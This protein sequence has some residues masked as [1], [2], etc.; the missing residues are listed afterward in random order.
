M[1]RRKFI[2]DA[3][4][5][6]A[7]AI[8]LAPLTASAQ[9]PSIQWKMQTS[10]ARGTDDSFKLLENFGARIATI[11]GDKFKVQVLPENEAVPNADLIGALGKGS[12]DAALTSGGDHIHVDKSFAF[13]SGMPFGMNARIQYAW[14]RF[15]G[16]REVLEELFNAHKLVHLPGGNTGVQ[17]AGFF[18]KEIKGL[19]DLNGLK[20]RVGGIGGEVLAKLGVAPQ[21][22]ASADIAAALKK[23]TLDAAEFQAP[24]NDEKL[25]LYK[26]AKFYYT[27]GF[28]DYT[29]ENSVF[30]NK[31]KWTQLPE[32]Y[33]ETV[34]ASAQHLSEQQLAFY[35]ANNADAL[36][37]MIQ[38][39]AQVRALPRE[40][41]AKAYDAAFDLYETEANRNPMFKKIYTQWSKFREDSYRWNSFNEFPLDNYV[42]ARLGSRGKTK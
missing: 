37:R 15:G 12:I 27:L 13:V 23:G 11:S 25:A 17:M 21:Q 19:A 35:D 26:E 32:A 7:A 24:V 10:Y 4:A 14:Y 28:W 18:K 41:L 1:D 16:G 39:G 33:R 34:I 38:G 6:G 20:M 30:I 9:A 5:G 40:V 31:D 8:T 29:N 42:T 22:V 3:A 2:R 36:N